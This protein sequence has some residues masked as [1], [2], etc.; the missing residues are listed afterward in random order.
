MTGK[1]ALVLG[2]SRGVGAAIRQA[3]LDSG[4]GAPSFGSRDINTADHASVLA[5]TAAY[6]A[7]DVLVLN[8]GGPSKK[9]FSEITKDEWETAH[10]QLFVSFATL[11]QK[12]EVRSGGFIFLVSSHLITEPKENMLLSAAY[13]LAFWSVL[14]ALSKTFAA[15]QVSCVNLALGPILTERLKALN[16]DMPALVDRQPMKRVGTPEEI[17]KLVRA[18]VEGNIKCL[19]GTTVVLDGSLSN[20]L[21]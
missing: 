21:F 19:S 20:A 8:T 5:F 12:I 7:T 3:L 4:Y 14:K 9:S 13:R 16:P 1:T 18:L 2:S 11:L 15:R 17:G 6:P 10:Q